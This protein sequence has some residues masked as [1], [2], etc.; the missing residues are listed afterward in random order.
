M[1]RAAAVDR[2]GNIYVSTEKDSR[3]HKYDPAGKEIA[4]WDVRDTAGN[5]YA[6]APPLVI[7]GDRLFALESVSAVYHPTSDLISYT[8]DGQLVGRVHACS[9]HFARGLAASRDGNFW[10]AD[11]GHNRVSK[12]SPSGTLLQ[13]LGDKGNAPGQFDEPASIWEAPDGTLFVADIGNERTQSFSPD[14]KPL[15]QWPIG[16]S[17]ARD[18]NRL[19]VDQAGNVVVTQVEDR[20]VVM[21]DKN[22]KELRRWVYRKG[23]EPLVPSGITALGGAKFLVLVPQSDVGAVFTALDN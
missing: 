19:T 16:R 21:Y 8:L 23:G 15:A 22:G 4:S 1:P 20:A 7:Q 2:H 17:I 18:G 6:D 11:T 10:L 12:V 5:P 9:C 3:I 14:L 13:T